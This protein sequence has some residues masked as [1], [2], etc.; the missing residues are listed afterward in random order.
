MARTPRWR[1]VTCPTTKAANRRWLF[2]FALALATVALATVAQGR[3]YSGQ[4]VQVGTPAACPDI[5]I[6]ITPGTWLALKHRDDA[7]FISPASV[8]IIKGIY[9]SSVPA[10]YLIDIGAGI[11]PGKVPAAS[12]SRRGNI[13]HFTFNDRKFQWVQAAGMHYYL[14]DGTKYWNGT[15]TDTRPM[16]SSSNATAPESTVIHRCGYDDGCHELLWAGDL[17]RDG[18]LDLIVRFSEGEDLGLELW[19]G[20]RDAQTLYFQNAARELYNYNMDFMCAWNR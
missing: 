19:L 8:S 3:P 1:V 14:T 4:I 13:F 10:D 17:N 18:N 15:W 16:R 7:W 9:Q 2:R 6:K 20:H 5:T 12:I 11:S